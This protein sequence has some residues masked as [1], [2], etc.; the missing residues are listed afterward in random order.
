ML[1]GSPA[2]TDCARSTAASRTTLVL[3]RVHDRPSPES[4]DLQREGEGEWDPRRPAA[5]PESWF[6]G[7]RDQRV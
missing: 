2:S 7:G 1:L 6:S 3:A 4:E 5:P